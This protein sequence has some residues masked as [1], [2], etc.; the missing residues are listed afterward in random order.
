MSVPPPARR[1]VPADPVDRSPG[2]TCGRCERATGNN[3]Q[4]HYWSHCKVTGTLR[5]FHFCCP[6]DCELAASDG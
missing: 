2:M 5:G 6:G 1:R 3:H 4:G